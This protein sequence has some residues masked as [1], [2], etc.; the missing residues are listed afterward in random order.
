MNEIKLISGLIIML[1]LVPL[2]VS[3]ESAYTFKSGGK[4]DL[5]VPCV[6]D[7]GSFCSIDT[8][9]TITIVDPNS[10]L[11]IDGQNMSFNVEY[12][13]YSLDTT[14][15]VT[16]G[17]YP[18]RVSCLGISD[19]GFTTF[20]FE[21]TPS[22]TNPSTGQSFMY[23]FF[24]LVSIILMIMCIV[25]SVNINGQNEFHMG[26][27][28][29]VNFNKYIKIGLGFLAY[30]FLLITFHLLWQISAKFL[31][32]DIATTLFEKL[33]LTLWILL[34]PVF[35]AFVAVALIKWMIDIR[36]EKLS[37]RNLGPR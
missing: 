5:K 29:S 12:F 21:V 15:S 30:L 6:N 36:L 7:D 24:L 17:E 34:L 32:L 19:N 9:C 8:N 27:L 25:G 10:V 33:Y 26:K 4:I 37:V 35:I 22:G 13:N 14:Q 3:A 2:I 28:L 31:W 16:L 20:N 23:I 18:T 1:L 11:I